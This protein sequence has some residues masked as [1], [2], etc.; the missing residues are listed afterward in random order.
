MARARA[1]TTKELSQRTW[2]DYVRFFSQG[3]GWD[4]CGC[5]FAH[6]FRPPKQLRK[7]ADKRDWNLDVKCRLVQEGRAHGIVVYA[8][9]EPVGWCQYGPAYELPIVEHGP[10]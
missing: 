3:N 2:T 5:T 4:H 6:G 8:R 10:R 9:G 7:Y 1:L